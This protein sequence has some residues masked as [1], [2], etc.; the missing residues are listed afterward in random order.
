VSFSESGAIAY[1]SSWV[2]N[3]R[4]H[5]LEMATGE[6]LSTAESTETLEMI[7]PVGVLASTR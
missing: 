7:G 5:A 4:V 2:Q 6:F 1:A 3:P